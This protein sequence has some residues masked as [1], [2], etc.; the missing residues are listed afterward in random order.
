MIYSGYVQKN[1]NL[2]NGMIFDKTNDKFSFKDN[3]IFP[4]E[5]LRILIENA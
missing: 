4:T 2:M 1:N 3:I 5:H